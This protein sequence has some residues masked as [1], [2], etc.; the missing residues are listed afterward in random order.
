MYG[1]EIQDDADVVPVAGVDKCLQLVCCPVSGSRA[2]KSGSLVSPGL[3]AGVFCERHDL[4]IIVAVLLQVGNQDIR[5]FFIVIPCIRLIGRLAEGTEVDLVDIQS[6][7]ETAGAL[8]H[9]GGVVKA[10]GIRFPDDGR[11]I[12]AQ[13]HP[14]SVGIAVVNELSGFIVDPV[15]V[16]HARSGVLRRE[17]PEVSV[18]DLLH[19]TLL[20]FIKFSD[21]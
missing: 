4:Q 21:D 2:E 3:V 19:G 20:P 10:E 13:F 1:H 16:H 5:H 15:L 17:F 7:L 6:F 8:F 11:C 18:V 12:R 9:P 14:V